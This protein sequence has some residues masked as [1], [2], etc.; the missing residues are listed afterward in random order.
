VLFYSQVS[1]FFIMVITEEAPVSTPS[2]PAQGNP[3]MTSGLLGLLS[4]V[5]SLPP[6]RGM[7][8]AP[9]PAVVEVESPFQFGGRGADAAGVHTSPFAVAEVRERGLA[10]TPSAD[11]MVSFDSLM[12]NQASDMASQAVNGLDHMRQELFGRYYDETEA[13]MKELR[14]AMEGGLARGRQAAV[15]RVDELSSVMHRDMV[16]LR[17][18]VQHELEDVK[19]DV[20]SAVMSLSALSDK[21]SA[22]DSRVAE[23][24][25]SVGR[26][27]S[28][29]M[30]KQYSA[31]QQYLSG[32]EARLDEIVAHKVATTLQQAIQELMRCQNAE[33]ATQ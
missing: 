7:S 5:P 8:S 21:M 27:L 31:T 3:G 11:E 13:R 20:F 26:G 12:N 22:A 25:A 6:S 14:H 19:R 9:A 2:R 28:E 30:D 10:A 1:I 29:R 17:Q 18:E 24:V 4:S 23:L 33:Y 32:L 16:A 15:E